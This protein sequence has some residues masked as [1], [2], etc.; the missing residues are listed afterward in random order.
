MLDLEERAPAWS[1][2]T[3]DLLQSPDWPRNER[4]RAAT[5]HDDVERRVAP[6]ERLE[7]AAHETCRRVAPSRDVEHRRREI[8]AAGPIP[9][10]EQDRRLESRPTTGVQR[11]ERSTFRRRRQSGSDEDRKSTRLN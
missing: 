8:D 11:A 6:R 3:A 7:I 9:Q 1:Q 4:Q 5:R 10:V 2:H